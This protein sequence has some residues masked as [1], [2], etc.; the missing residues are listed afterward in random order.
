MNQRDEELLEKQL[1]AINL[2]PRYDGVIIVT[3]LVGFL[4]GMNSWRFPRW[5][6]KRADARSFQRC[7]AHCLPELRACAP[8][9]VTLGATPVHPG[10][11]GRGVYPLAS[12]TMK[13][14]ANSS[15][16]HGYGDHRTIFSRSKWRTAD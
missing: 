8:T 11:R 15:I 7:G 1:R 3:L 10:K 6:H 14:S 2:T 5:S 4:A 12:R 13:H 16:D 9:P